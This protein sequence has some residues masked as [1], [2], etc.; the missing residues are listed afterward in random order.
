VAYSVR[1]SDRWWNDDHSGVDVVLGDFESDE[2][3]HHEDD[4]Y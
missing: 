2:D 3:D 4:H 1:Q